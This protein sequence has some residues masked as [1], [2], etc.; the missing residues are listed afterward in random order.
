M[1]VPP[2]VLF[3]F[4]TEKFGRGKSFSVYWSVK[5]PPNPFVICFLG[6][7]QSSNNHDC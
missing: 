6:D 7:R 4:V 2:R 5:N 3:T 1:V